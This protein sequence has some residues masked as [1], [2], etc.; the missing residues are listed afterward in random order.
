MATKIVEITDFEYVPESVAIEVGDTVKW[1]NRDDVQHNAHRTSAPTFDTGLLAKNQEK[2]IAFSQ[3]SDAKG[4]EYSCSPHSFMTGHV[5]VAMPG[6][7]IAAY[8]REAA[9][10]LH[11][12]HGAGGN[13]DKKKP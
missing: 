13:D 8:T 3:A 6:S 9:R 1:I 7:H 10:L 5:V 11:G 12:K 4:F 2:E